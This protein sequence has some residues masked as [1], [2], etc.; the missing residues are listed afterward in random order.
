M[1]DQELKKRVAP[2][3]KSCVHASPALQADTVSVTVRIMYPC[4]DSILNIWKVYRKSIVQIIMTSGKAILIFS[5]TPSCD[6]N[7]LARRHN[8]LD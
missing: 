2:L 3:T 4:V 1:H 7:S 6:Q 8:Y 5:W